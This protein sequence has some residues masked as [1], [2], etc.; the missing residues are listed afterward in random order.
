[1]KVKKESGEE[2]EFDQSRKE[3]LDGLIR[4]GTLKPVHTS[5]KNG[6]K[7]FGSRFNNELKKLGGIL[8]R[9]RN[10]VGKTTQMMTQHILYLWKV[11]TVMDI[12]TQ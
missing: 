5:W 6:N 10:S 12:Y 3:E 7:I 2:K 11:K 1:M 8:K 4:Y 9:K